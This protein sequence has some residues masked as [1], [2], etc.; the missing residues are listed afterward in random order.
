[1]DLSTP[2]PYRLVERGGAGFSCDEDGLALGGVSLIH[3]AAG[4]EGRPRYEVR[5]VD[6]IDHIL[7]A[8]FG[9]QPRATVLRVHRGLGRAASG[10]LPSNLIALP[11][12]LQT[13]AD[14][15]GELPLHRGPHGNYDKDTQA[16]INALVVAIPEEMNPQTARSVLEAVSM[17]NRI[18]ILGGYYNPFMKLHHG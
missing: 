9:P 17:I 1:M 18:K 7:R 16:L 11:K 15:G 14:V 8:A 13:Q 5:S 6:E 4:A 2:R 3:G 10:D 12:D